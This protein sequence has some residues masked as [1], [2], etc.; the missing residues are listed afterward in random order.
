[1]KYK[2]L[3]HKIVFFGALTLLLVGIPFCRPFM[4]IGGIILI[5]NW[6][7]EF[8]FIEKYHK[9][10]RNK[11]LL[12]SLLFFMLYF[13]GMI[14]TENT[15]EGWQEIWMKTPLLFLPIIFATSE[16][17]TKQ[18]FQNFLKIYLIGVM[19][20]S[21]Y[22]FI[23]YHS[24]DLID[25][26][27]IAVFISYIRFEMN[28]C[29]ALFV[30]MYLIVKERDKKWQTYIIF[31]FLAWFLFLIFYIGALTAISIA[32]CVSLYVVLKKM[33]ES[34]NKIYRIF[35]PLLLLI[36][37]VTSI[38]YTAILIKQYYKVD[39]KDK[40]FD[41]LTAYGNTYLP[42][43]ENSIIENGNYVY[44]YICK[45]EL[46]EAWNE[47]SN[48]K[49]SH[50][51]THN[52]HKIENTLIR[53]LNS[54]G[55]R[56]DRQGVE[57]LSDEEITHIENG[58]ANVVYLNKLGFKSRLYGLLWELSDY[59]TNGSISGYTIPQRFELWKNSLFLIKKYPF[60]GVGTGDV[61]QKFAKQLQISQSPLQD[62]NKLSHNQFLFFIMQFGVIG[63]LIILY[64]IIFPFITNKTYKHDLFVIFILI[65]FLAMLTDDTFQRQ[66]G[67]T[68]FAFFYFFFLFL[69]PQKENLLKENTSDKNFT[70]EI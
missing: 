2:D 26:R 9:I 41:N 31:L 22:G 58:I 6:F 49:F 19:I 8:N 51:D 48:I 25:K 27:E 50:K 37:S 70:R 52:Q 57:H 1:M 3:F 53:Y 13:V 33:I 40:S 47:R 17:L 7:L 21:V 20:S 42:L 11:P 56:K 10:V 5:V 34:K 65:V 69:T 14:Y 29:F 45:K 36:T 15:R 12:I 43:A 38:S 60:I 46:E 54:K 68:F 63:F 30:S 55:L 35:L 16:S 61:K 62:S 4:T 66:D 24:K 39:E 59:K 32:I 28:L 18:H 44:A 64:S 67:L 23:M